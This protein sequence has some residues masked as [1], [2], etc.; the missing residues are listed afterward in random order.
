MVNM[1]F[2][3][4]MKRIIQSGF[5]I[6]DCL[7]YVE[8][9]PT[10]RACFDSS[11]FQIQSWKP[12]KTSKRRRRTLG[13]RFRSSNDFFNFYKWSTSSRSHDVNI[14]W[15]FPNHKAQWRN[16]TARTNLLK[17]LLSEFCCIRSNL[18]ID[19]LI[20]SEK[21]CPNIVTFRHEVSGLVLTWCY[22]SF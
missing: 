12:E 1:C 21:V 13:K 22:S 7:W 3:N 5:Y 2:Q 11:F 6:C 4:H 19:Y 9:E 20:S 17:N 15:I 14:I 8:F 18:P 16:M 10:I